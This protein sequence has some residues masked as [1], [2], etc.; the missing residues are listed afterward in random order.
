MT[1]AFYSSRGLTCN[2]GGCCAD[3]GFVD[4]PDYVTLGE[5]GID[6]GGII[7]QA[8]NIGGAVFVSHLQPSQINP[9]SSIPE[10]DQVALAVYANIDG[11]IPMI[12]RGEVTPADASAAARRFQAVWLQYRGQTRDGRHSYLDQITGAVGIKVRLVDEAGAR[13]ISLHSGVAS[14]PAS[15]VP[16]TSEAA[17]FP[18]AGVTASTG[19]GFTVTPTML[20]W[21]GGGL[22]ALVIFYFLFR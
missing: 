14:V 8:I 13:Y 1:V 4:G 19:I 5:L 18:G 7:G 21:G 6:W 22:L 16:G 10:A 2:G 12:E 15:L 20:L 11:L 17:Q 9:N 3:C